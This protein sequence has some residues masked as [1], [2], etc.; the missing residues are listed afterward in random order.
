MTTR[1]L[2]AL[3]LGMLLLVCPL[4][5][6]CSSTQ[7]TENTSS[8]AGTTSEN[9]TAGN[10]TDKENSKYLDENGMY[11][12]ENMNMP[13]FNFNYDTFTVCVYSNEVQDTYH[14]EEIMP[15]DTTDDALKKGVLDRNDL[16]EEK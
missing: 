3:L 12:L 8:T 6:S 9:S 5:A 1:R 14:S 13:A 10:E 2:F 16:V 7:S 15:I 11:T 4:L